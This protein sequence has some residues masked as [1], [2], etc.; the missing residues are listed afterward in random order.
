MHSYS[1]MNN[2]HRMAAF[3]PG[4]VHRRNFDDMVTSHSATDSAPLPD[5]D[6]IRPTL[7]E[8]IRFYTHFPYRMTQL[9][10]KIQE[11]TVVLRGRVNQMTRTIGECDTPHQT[12][13]IVCFNCM[14]Q[15]YV[16]IV[17]STR[18]LHP[19]PTTSLCELAVMA[20]TLREAY[21]QGACCYLLLWFFNDWPL[22]IY[23]ICVC[24]WVDP[25]ETIMCSV[26]CV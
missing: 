26:Q 25:Q 15:S 4:G 1:N 9:D 23:L 7:W 10:A 13:S 5:Q 16:S 12:V 17:R 22:A 19:D 2:W 14:F 20:A 3:L 21:F 18:Y 6:D 8:T 24:C 11:W